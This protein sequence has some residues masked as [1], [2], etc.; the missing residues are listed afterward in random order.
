VN[1]WLFM[2]AKDIDVPTLSIEPTQLFLPGSVGIHCREVGENSQAMQIWLY[3]WR[4]M[5]EIEREGW[6]LIRRSYFNKRFLSQIHSFGSGTL[7]L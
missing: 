6:L 3:Y 2:P 5:T 1:N 4:D 7:S